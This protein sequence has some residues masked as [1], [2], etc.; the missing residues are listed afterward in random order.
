MA[1][2]TAR[3]TTKKGGYAG[4]EAELWAHSRNDDGDPHMLIDHLRSVAEMARI[5]IQRKHLSP[6]GD[7]DSNRKDI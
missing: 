4:S 3:S 7:V 6:F 5:F 1:R 2:S